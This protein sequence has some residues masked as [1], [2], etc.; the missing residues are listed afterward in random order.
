MR[1]KHIDVFILGLY[2]LIIIYIINTILNKK[3]HGLVILSIILVIHINI[4]KFIKDNYVITIDVKQGDSSLLYLD[5]KA[6]LIDTGGLYNQIVVEKTIIMK[7]SM[8]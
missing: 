2:I 5:D 3:I 8:I 6:I 4:N 1:I 7:F